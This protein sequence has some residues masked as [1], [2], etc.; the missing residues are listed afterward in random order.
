MFEI[1]EQAAIHNLNKTAEFITRMRA[2]K[3][4]T[5]IE[6]FGTS[7]QATQ[8]MSRLQADFFKIDGTLINGMPD[9]KDVQ[10]RVKSLAKQFAA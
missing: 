7:E 10:A 2:M 9:K 1:G 3:C 6:H 4:R 8:V 5:A